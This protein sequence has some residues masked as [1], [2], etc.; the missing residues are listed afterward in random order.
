MS[1]SE[2]LDSIYERIGG[3]E[4]MTDELSERI[5]TLEDLVNPKP[6]YLIS[7]EP[8]IQEEGCGCGH[9]KSCWDCAAIIAGC[10]ED[11]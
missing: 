10:P 6:S 4:P 2:E 9:P 3:G 11:V 5:A 7:C 8:V 1:P